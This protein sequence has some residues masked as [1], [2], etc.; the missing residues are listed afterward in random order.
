ML[1]NPMTAPSV[2]HPGEL[3]VQSKTGVRA[4][5]ASAGLSSYVREAMP[6]QHRTFFESQPLMYIASTDPRGRPWASVLV[7]RPGF[8]KATSPKRVDIQPLR[9]PRLDPLAGCL[10][11]GAFVGM[12]GLEHHTRRR[13]RLNGVVAAALPTAPATAPAPAAASTPAPSDT[14]DGSYV[15]VATAPYCG[16]MTI[17][18]S[19]S[20]GNCPK[21]IQGRQLTF[22]WEAWDHSFS[23]DS[24]A[25]TAA[26]EP[27]LVEAAPVLPSPQSV[28]TSVAGSVPPLARDGV[29]GGTTLGPA[30][31]RLIRR[32]D[33]FF[34]ASCYAGPSPPDTKAAAVGCDVSHRGGPA[35]FVKI[36]ET[37]QGTRL[38]WADYAGNNMFQTLGNLALNPS[39]GLL[40]I[41]YLSGDTLHLTGKAWVDFEDRSLPGAM[42]TVSFDVQG[43]VHIPHALPL[44]QQGPIDWSPFLPQTPAAIQAGLESDVDEENQT[45]SATEVGK[46][47]VSSTEA[48]QCVSVVKD[49]AD[50]STFEFRLPTSKASSGSAP[51]LPGQYASFEFPHSQVYTTA[52]DVAA[53]A[54]GEIVRTWT[55]SSH[56]A[57][58]MRTG[59]FTIS[60]KRAGAVSSYL[61]TSMR[62]GATIAFRAFGGDFVPMKSLPALP[63]SP[64]ASAVADVQAG[65]MVVLLAAGIGIT[66]IRVMFHE[67]LLRAQAALTPSPGSGTKPASS[68]ASSAIPTPPSQGALTFPRELLLIYC[69]R[70]LKDAAFLDELAAAANTAATPASKATSGAGE[71]RVRI[72]LCVSKDEVG[73]QGQERWPGVTMHVGRLTRQVLVQHI[74]SG[75]TGHAMQA[76]HAVY[77]CG[78]MG[79]M[80][81]AE[82]ELAAEGLGMSR[83]FTESFAF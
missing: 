81:T 35:G 71:I 16:A 9:L 53:D 70:T 46:T 29:A 37:E 7:G 75:Q 3:Q 44:R 83:L 48:L 34:I 57:W 76:V 39:A 36:S 15:S 27:G 72:V 21:Y 50:I 1:S 77:M 12:L 5:V 67:F 69:V 24:A 11:P 10:A 32:S 6:D 43:F 51:Y 68:S 23:S 52:D 20:F 38:C 49:T 45:R 42:R 47:E 61:H 59:T 64:A 78:P 82:D 28:A 62:P 55:V 40:F 65:G 4:H 22:D 56:P 80:S 18:V 60:V 17:D 31:R 19:L 41:D 30:Q 14:A 33:T 54:D 13:N 73:E 79:F 63:P 58:S 2:F 25:T 66:P 26:P 74:Q 8:V